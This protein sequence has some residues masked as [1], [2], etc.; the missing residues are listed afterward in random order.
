MSFQ[1]K[2]WKVRTWSNRIGCCEKTRHSELAREES[3]SERVVRATD[4]AVVVEV[5][6]RRDPGVR[7]GDE[8]IG[9]VD[10]IGGGLATEAVCEV[11]IVV[12]EC[13]R[14]RVVR[15]EVELVDQ[16]YLGPD[17]LD[18]LRHRVRLGVAGHRQFRQGLTV[19]SCGSATR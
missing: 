13:L 16:Q 18:D 12:L 4:D 3:E 10:G 19:R 15:F 8:D 9:E 17:A 1:R 7:R 14:Q 11:E 6:A 5:E 2:C